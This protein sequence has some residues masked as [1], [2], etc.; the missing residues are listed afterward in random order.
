ML[1]ARRYVQRT[2]DIHR[3]R[4]DL[5]DVLCRENAHLD[6]QLYRKLQIYADIKK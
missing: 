5:I 2:A 1:R 6:V 3:K 4:A